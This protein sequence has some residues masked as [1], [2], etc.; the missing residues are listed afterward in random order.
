MG[1]VALSVV[2]VVGALATGA[3][4]DVLAVVSVVLGALPV[5]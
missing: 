2:S 4:V 5:V 1:A 3:E